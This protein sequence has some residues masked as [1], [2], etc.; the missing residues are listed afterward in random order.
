MSVRVEYAFQAYRMAAISKCA[1]LATAELTPAT[2]AESYTALD[3]CTPEG[4]LH[5]GNPTGGAA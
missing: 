4:V 5:P 1:A 2:K 3:S